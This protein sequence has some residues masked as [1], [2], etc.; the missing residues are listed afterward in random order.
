MADKEQPTTTSNKSFLYETLDQQY[1]DAILMLY[2]GWSYQRIAKE[3]KITY[4]AIRRWFMTGGICKP[5]Y[6]ELLKEHAKENRR[7]VKK[8]DKKIDEYLPDALETLYTAARSGNWK[9]AE[10]LLHIGGK[11]PVQKIKAEVET[12][13]N[14]EKIKESAKQIAEYVRQNLP[15]GNKENT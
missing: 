3:L 12:K 2:G 1:Q 14:D 10:S 15:G 5:A 6:D 9:A 8:I 4:G 13:E 11:V 7:K